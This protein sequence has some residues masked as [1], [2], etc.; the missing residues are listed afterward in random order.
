[1]KKATDKRPHGGRARAMLLMVLAVAMQMFGCGQADSAGSR[2]AKTQPATA[3]S[4]TTVPKV[5]GADDDLAVRAKAMVAT[6]PAQTEPAYKTEP[7]YPSGHL[8]GLCYIPT[9]ALV[10]R[11]SAPKAEVWAFTGAG[12]IP[13]A[14]AGEVEYYRNLGITKP[15]G[16]HIGA[17]HAA[18]YG[19][20]GG[21]AFLRDIKAGPKG[22]LGR[23]GFTAQYGQITCQRHGGY[24]LTNLGFG[25]VGE[26]IL[27][28]SVDSFP[29][30]FVVTGAESGKVVFDGVADAYGKLAKPTERDERR[31]GRPDPRAFRPKILQSDRVTEPGLYI[32]TCKRHPWQRAYLWVSEHPYVAEVG[33]GRRGRNAG[34]FSIRN[35]PVGTHTLEVWHPAYEPVRKTVEVQIKHNETTEVLVEFKPPPAARRKPKPPAQRGK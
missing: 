13:K 1:M 17:R 22:P 29:C 35:I 8:N 34:M 32:I 6:Q 11:P 33:G 20:I 28:G 23:P 18:G 15:T 7:K 14:L 25:P 24:G 31:G 19:V 26:R 2:R 30:Q 27:F 16:W 10:P 12:A 9:Q 21:A 4:P 5:P 3:D